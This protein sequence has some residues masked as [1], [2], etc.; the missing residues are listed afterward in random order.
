MAQADEDLL[1]G[2]G[3]QGAAAIGL[4]RNLIV[5]LR[6]KGV[7]SD[8]ELAAI[9]DASAEMARSNGGR[10]NQRFAEAVRQTIRDLEDSISP[11]PSSKQH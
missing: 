4:L 10:I 5:A 7:I 8:L 3:H 6:S 1:I 9:F 11:S 2:I